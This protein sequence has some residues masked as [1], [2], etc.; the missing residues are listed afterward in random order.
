MTG[1]NTAWI[2]QGLPVLMAIVFEL[3]AGLAFFVGYP[4][5]AVAKEAPTIKAVRL[6]EVPAPEPRPETKAPA[7]QI[8]AAAAPPMIGFDGKPVEMP[9]TR[10]T[11]KPVMH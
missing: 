5:P 3:G 2:G 9:K 6:V 7:R 11:K 8:K 10:R 4:S 1:L